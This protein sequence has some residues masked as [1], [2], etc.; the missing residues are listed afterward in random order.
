M[1]LLLADDE[2]VIL[3]GLKKL[4][5]WNEYGLEIIGEANNGLELLKSVEELTP[6]IIISDICMPGLTGVDVIKKI[7]ELNM[8]TKVIFVSGFEEFSYVKEAMKNGAIDYL[9]KPINKIELE[10]VIMHTV[11]LIDKEKKEFDMRDK[12]LLLEKKNHIESIRSLLDSLINGELKSSEGMNILRKINLEGP[13]FSVAV[14]EVGQFKNT[15]QKWDERDRKLIEFS[16]SNITNEIIIEDKKGAFYLKD[17]KFV[18]ILNHNAEVINRLT[19]LIININ[20]LLDL[21]VTIGVGNPVVNIEEVSESFQT[22][23]QS[24]D[25]KFYHGPNQVIPYQEFKQKG[26]TEQ[27]LFEY[28]NIIM[29]CF[30]SADVKKLEL[31][32]SELCQNIEE[33]SFGDKGIAVSTCYSFVLILVQ[34]LQK[35]D[36]NLKS[37]DPSVEQLKSKMKELHYYSDLRNV[38]KDI[39]L[40]LFY[41]ITENSVNKETLIM[42]RAKKYIEEHFNEDITLETVAGIAYM[43]P[44]YF[45]SFFKKHTNQNFKQYLTEIRMNHASRLL[46]HSDMLVYEIAEKVGYNNPRQFSDMFRRTFGKLPNDYKQQFKKA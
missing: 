7:R 10:K 46:L 5:P 45:S 43:N 18:I 14:L 34:S 29:Q 22:A 27:E 44:Y 37:L 42:L 41:F 33:S 13:K 16:I 28:Q 32:L 30:L 1:R 6:E 25:A 17:N 23:I 3:R 11:S 21:E 8:N 31:S 12:L 19:R 2:P 4:L 36:V 38:L 40:K 9:V 39:I 24:L 15:N 35:F 20:Q 26:L